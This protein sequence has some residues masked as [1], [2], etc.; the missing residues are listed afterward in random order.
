MNTNDINTENLETEAVAA[1]TAETAAAA[2]TPVPAEPEAEEAEKEAETADAAEKTAD[3][4]EPS[5]KP[6]LA[7]WKKLLI[8]CGV[9][10]VL[11]GA[12]CAVMWNVMEQYEA[13][14]PWYAV[15]EYLHT[16]TQSAFYTALLSAYPDTQNPYEPIYEIAGDLSA[17]Y[18]STLTYSKL[19][20]EYTY[21]TPVYLLQSGDTKLLKLTLTQGEKTGFLGLRGYRVRSTEL[22]ASELFELRSYGLVFPS[23]AEVQVNGKALSVDTIAAESAFTAFG[24]GD[25]TVCMLENFFERP[26]VKVV[27]AGIELTES[28]SG[29]FLFDY[30]EGKLRTLTITAPADAIVRIDG[31]RVSEYFRTETS[32]SEAD[33]FGATVELCTYTVPTV[34]GEGLVTVT[35]DGVSLQAEQNE[36]VWTAQPTI[37]S[38]T[39]ILPKDAVLYA[40]G[41][42]VDA[43]CITAEDTVWSPAFEGVRNYPRAV[44]YTLSFYAQPELTAALSGTALVET[45]DGESIVFVQAADET[46]KETYSAQAIDFMNAYLY[47]TTQG[48]SNTRANLDA[49]KAHVA[50]PSPLYTNLERSYIGY[51]YISPQKMT[52]ESMTVD[53]FVPYGEDAFT[54]ELSY[55]ITL[56]NWVGETTEENTMRIAF[57]KSGG[58]FAPV[59]MLLAEE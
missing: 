1:D 45:Q 38:C 35:L 44:T 56:K 16:S 11:I 52:V 15:E 6:R 48:Y 13:A 40:N 41:N 51:Y 34:S 49:V 58:K 42:A 28:G 55:K 47:Y 10:L 18:G 59:N 43:S 46:L 22:V 21:E 20:R 54:C 31:K 37:E 50:N 8:Y 30:P 7:F 19:I 33:P 32:V 3:T 26:T 5:K 12:A 9:W 36:N 25:F 57:T 2:E 39:V 14:Q 17:K 24:S 29:D 23:G 4:P 53:N 27:Y